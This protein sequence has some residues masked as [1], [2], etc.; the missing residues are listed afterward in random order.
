MSEDSPTVVIAGSGDPAGPPE[1][2][3]RVADAIPGARLLIVPGAHLANL[4]APCSVTEA[5]VEHFTAEVW[6]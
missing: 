6:A 3:R 4:E 2:A 5:I 1:H